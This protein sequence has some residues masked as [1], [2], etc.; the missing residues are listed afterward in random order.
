MEIDWKL[1]EYVKNQLKH[2]S[3]TLTES[4]NTD[5]QADESQEA[6]Q[7]EF[8]HL[9]LIDLAC[10]NHLISKNAQFKTVFKEARKQFLKGKKFKI[11]SR[12]FAEIYRQM[13]EKGVEI[14]LIHE[15]LYE[16]GKDSDF[17][18]LMYSFDARFE[19]LHFTNRFL[20][21]K[22]QKYVD[23]QVVVEA[24]LDPYNLVTKIEETGRDG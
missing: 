7:A 11:Y 17:K 18:P 24:I 22:L 2:N 12:L 4:K 1:N 13:V 14:G 16:P 3:G 5:D 8:S 20:K 19:L 6:R 9:K 15:I 21:K 23:E 10:E